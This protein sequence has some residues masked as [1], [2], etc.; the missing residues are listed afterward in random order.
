MDLRAVYG[1]I[2]KGCRALCEGSS[3]GEGAGRGDRLGGQE[4]WRWKELVY[5]YVSMGL[6]Q[7]D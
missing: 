1:C 3:F 2:G 6:T 7:G 4:D 5:V